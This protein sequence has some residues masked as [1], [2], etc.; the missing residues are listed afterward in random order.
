MCSYAF[1]NNIQQPE[2]PAAHSRLGVT[3]PLLLL[4][5]PVDNPSVRNSLRQSAALKL[6]DFRI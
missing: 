5:L 6:C 4:I 3:L 1:W 2:G